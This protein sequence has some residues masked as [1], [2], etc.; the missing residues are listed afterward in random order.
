M[1]DLNLMVPEWAYHQFQEVRFCRLTGTTL[2]DSFDTG[3]RPAGRAGRGSE[4][5]SYRE[6][7][8]GDPL[9]IIDWRSLARHAYRDDPP[10]YVRTF[11]AELA[12]LT[13]I[14]VD[15][16][17]S[18][19]TNP[20]D[21]V[22]EKKFE[23]AVGVAGILAMTAAVHGDPVEIAFCGCLAEEPI[24][25]TQI[26]RGLQD[27]KVQFAQ[28]EDLRFVA[29]ER[30]WDLPA[31]P[32]H[33][34]RGTRQTLIFISD[35]FALPEVIDEAFS[36]WHSLV[37]TLMAVQV[38]APSDLDPFSDGRA[39]E[40]YDVENRTEKRPIHADP[41]KYTNVLEA[42]SQVVDK[43]MQYYSVP[44]A[45]ITACSPGTQSRRGP[46][47]MDPREIVHKLKHK[48]IIID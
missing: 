36:T 18:M 8:P 19:N 25:M 30:F 7:I 35:F 38:R 47:G 42:H 10:V 12:N 28:L 37:R 13:T 20:S 2:V 43:I 5:Y 27:L 23:S 45:E 21:K 41:E 29:G 44:F 15:C 39:Y 16:T 3:Q 17:A 46:A 4:W 9:N 6:F 32:F 14:C 48:R 31:D 26:M 11:E 40:F 24:F 1:I 34:L 33:G 22:D